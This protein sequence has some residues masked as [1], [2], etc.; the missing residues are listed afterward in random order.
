MFGTKTAEPE[1]RPPLAGVV[2]V[3]KLDVKPEKAQELLSHWLEHG[4]ELRS[5]EA[6]QLN[7]QTVFV[8]AF[9]VAP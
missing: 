8:L 6:V 7:G 2:Q 4:W 1:V 3:L 9:L 5:T